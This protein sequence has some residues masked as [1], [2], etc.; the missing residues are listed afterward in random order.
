MENNDDF[1][2]LSDKEKLHAENELLK[3]KLQAEFGMNSLETNLNSQTEN[4]WLNNIYSFEQ[5]FAE[6]KQCKLYD[7]IN[8]P[9]YIK[10]DVLSDEQITVELKKVLEVLQLHNIFLDTICDYDDN[11]IYQF[12][13]EELFEEEIDDIRIDGMMHHFIYE[14]FH[15]N[16]DYDL[17]KNATQFI[18]LLLPKKWDSYLNNILLASAIIYNNTEHSQKSLASIIEAFQ[19]EHPKIELLSWQVSSVNFNLEINSASV[20]GFVSY[21]S[22]NTA[23]E[24]TVSLDFIMS[25]DFWSISKVIVPGF[26]N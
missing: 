11:V 6:R 5:Q 4:Q 17:R 23:F 7:F 12:I 22:N 10:T 20:I 16:H 8:C 14:E 24:G 3:L 1:E 9:S 18:E 15:P 13:T 21:I 26:G 2:D 19:T 25:Y